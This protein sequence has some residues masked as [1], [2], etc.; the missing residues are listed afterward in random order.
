MKAAKTLLVL[1]SIIFVAG[2]VALRIRGPWV[3]PLYEADSRYEYRLKPLQHTRNG[4]ANIITN[5]FGMR[6]GPVAAKKGKRVLFIG[7]SVISG[8]EWVDNDSLATTLAGN[9]LSER[10]G[11]T[12]EVLNASSPSWG[13]DNAAAY[14]LACGLFDADLIV[15][16]WN[17]DDHGD[18]MGFEPVVGKNPYFRD[19]QRI[20][21]LGHAW[22]EFLIRTGRAGAFPDGPSGFNT[23]WYSL[24]DLATDAG[25]PFT[26]VMHPRVI[27]RQAGA[28]AP[29]GTALRDSLSAWGV[30]HS[31]T[32][33][34]LDDGH[35]A[36]DIHL[37]VAGQAALAQF[38]AGH[39]E[40]A[41][42][43]AAE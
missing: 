16:V 32:W 8:M 23:G 33:N 7:D 34:A 1:V 42:A 36:D 26:V 37:S 15:G 4:T 39:I 25:I 38:L 43:R 3:R 5:A 41:F 40:E 10:S 35:Y 31:D 18:R 20:T 9:I 22:D 6:S 14:L 27:E 29:Q 17:S 12:V 13:P 21:A 28:W 19:R 11:M 2:E 24:R 30:P